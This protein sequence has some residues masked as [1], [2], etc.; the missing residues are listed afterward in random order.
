MNTDRLIRL[1]DTLDQAL[2]QLE[3][4]SQTNVRYDLFRNS[5]IKSFE[6]GLETAGK[7]LRKSLKQFL[8]SARSADMLTFNDVIRHSAKHGLLDTNEAERRLQYRRNRN[9]TAQDYGERFAN[10]TLILLPAFSRDLRRL[11]DRLGSLAADE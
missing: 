7:A 1:S 3:L 6:L 2:E 5:A 8:G 9:T 11:A 10:E 4:E